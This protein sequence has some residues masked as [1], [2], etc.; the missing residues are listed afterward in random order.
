MVRFGSVR[1][2]FFFLFFAVLNPVTL[3][4]EFKGKSAE[5]T[6]TNSYKLRNP[7]EKL[8]IFLQRNKQRENEGGGLSLGERIVTLRHYIQELEQNNISTLDL[9]VY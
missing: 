7:D 1:E 6:F 5:T 4:H 8:F 3:D 9:F 2:F